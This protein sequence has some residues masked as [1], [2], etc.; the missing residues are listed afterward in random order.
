MQPP[1]L[2]SRELFDMRQERDDVVL[3][4]ALDLVDARRVENEVLGA[5][6]RRGSTRDEARF[7]HGVARGELDVEPDGKSARGRPKLGKI[8]G[9]VARDHAQPI[10]TSFAKHGSRRLRSKPDPAPG[11]RRRNGSEETNNYIRIRFMHKRYTFL[12]ADPPSRGNQ[13]IG[14]RTWQAGC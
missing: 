5:Q 1:R 7:L 4:G 10:S 14:D 6:A 12:R 11:D 2:D 8:G 9:R 3:G 13:R